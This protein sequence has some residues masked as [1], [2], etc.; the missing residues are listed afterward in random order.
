MSRLGGLCKVL[1]KCILGRLEQDKEN[2]LDIL[3]MEKITKQLLTK[4]RRAILSFLLDW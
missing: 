4:T 3:D 1:L 2:L